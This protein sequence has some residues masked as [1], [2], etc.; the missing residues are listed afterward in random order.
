[1]TGKSNS[2]GRHKE[3]ERLQSET[4]Q[5]G[6]PIEAQ[7]KPDMTRLDILAQVAELEYRMN[8]PVSREPNLT[9]NKDKE[10]PVGVEHFSKRKADMTGHTKEMTESMKRRPGKRKANTV[11]DTTDAKQEMKRPKPAD[12]R[13]QVL[14][15]LKAYAND[16]NSKNIAALRTVLKSSFGFD[17]K[18]PVHVIFDMIKY[19]DMGKPLRDQLDAPFKSPKWVGFLDEMRVG[20][21]KKELAH[22]ELPVSQG[23]DEA[24]ATN[25]NPRA[26]HNELRQTVK[27][28]DEKSTGAEASTTNQKD[29]TINKGTE[30]RDELWEAMGKMLYDGLR[31]WETHGDHREPPIIQS[32]AE[33]L[34]LIYLLR[35]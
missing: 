4:G 10:S 9:F 32:L 7:T 29:A 31:W 25:V 3:D 17:I 30:S 27:G 19:L 14:R 28:V 13:L 6:K 2:S 35:P 23:D 24:T 34:D 12:P 5:G 11:V 15:S 22:T 1:M 20:T 18:T 33:L 8:F 21:K 26:V 16:T